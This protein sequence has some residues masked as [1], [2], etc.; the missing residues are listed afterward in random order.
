MMYR[1]P[2]VLSAEEVRQLVG[3]LEQAEWV[4]GRATVGAQGAQV[5]QNQQVDTRSE[6]YARL[7]ARVLD[8]VNRHSLFFAAAL[9]KP[10]PARCSTAI[11][12]K[13]PTV[14]TS[15][16]RYVSTHTPAG[17][18]PTFPPPCSC[19]NRIATKAVS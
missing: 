1:I 8:A 10:F 18:A 7:Q 13:K 16:A 6:H 4:D 9:P 12:S 15:T 17:C 11:S 3:E 19:R 14:F 2:G 5:K